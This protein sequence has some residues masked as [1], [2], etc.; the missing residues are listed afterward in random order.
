MKHLEKTLGFSLDSG[1]P[2]ARQSY[3]QRCIHLQLT[4]LGLPRASPRGDAA[5][6]DIA[7]RLLASYGR[8]PAC[9][10]I[11]AARPTAASNLFCNSTWLI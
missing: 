9:W 5:V 7:S 10:K 6:L 4:A 1:N 8:N 2:A 11:T 3:L